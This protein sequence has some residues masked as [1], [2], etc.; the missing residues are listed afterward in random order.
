MFFTFKDLYSQC[1]SPGLIRYVEA[2][3]LNPCKNEDVLEASLADL[4]IDLLGEYCLDVLAKI[5]LKSNNFR[6]FKATKMFNYLKQ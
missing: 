4:I 1:N 6:Q 2:I 3:I 5:L